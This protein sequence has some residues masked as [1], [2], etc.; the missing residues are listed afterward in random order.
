MTGDEKNAPQCGVVW[1]RVASGFRVPWL[2]QKSRPSR[3]DVRWTTCDRDLQHVV[4]LE[5]LQRPPADFGRAGQARGVRGRG[6]SARISGYFARRDA[7]EADD[8]A[9]PQL[10]EHG[11]GGEHPRQSARRGGAA[12]RLRQNDASLSDGSGER[13]FADHCGD[14]WTDAQRQVPQ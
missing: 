9:L 11:R 5:S 2:D 4:G 10:G 6:L 1:R 3:T 7:D 13:G 8:H 12:D 14:G